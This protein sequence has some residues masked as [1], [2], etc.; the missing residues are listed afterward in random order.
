MSLERHVAA[1]YARGGLGRLILEALAESGKDVE[2]LS[3]ED[4]APIDEFHFRG[5]DATLEGP[6][7]RKSRQFCSLRGC[8]DRWRGL[9][10]AVSCFQYPVSR[11]RSR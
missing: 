10:K 6:Q 9:A 3:L 8:T 2:R 5:R 1:H 4:L 11:I 7:V